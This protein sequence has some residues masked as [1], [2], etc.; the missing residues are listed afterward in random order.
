[1]VLC[2]LT[3]LFVFIPGIQFFEIPVFSVTWES[4]RSLLLLLL[5]S[6]YSIPRTLLYE[7][8]PPCGL[9]GLA[10]VSFLISLGSCQIYSPFFKFTYSFFCH[11][12]LQLSLCE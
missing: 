8:V 7:V 6:R 1:M 10:S 5:S 9:S 2:L 4:P 11:S 3:D 12:H